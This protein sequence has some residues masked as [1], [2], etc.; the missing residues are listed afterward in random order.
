[1]ENIYEWLYD[2]YAEPQLRKLPPFADSRVT[3]MVDAAAP[4]GKRLDLKDRINSLR[5]DCCTE[6]F[7][8]GVRLGMQLS[9]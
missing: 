2:H 8:L 5:L 6:A 1:M 9:L 4:E 3:A 7:A